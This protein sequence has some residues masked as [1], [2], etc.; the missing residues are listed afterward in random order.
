MY[1]LEARVPEIVC[2]ANLCSDVVDKTRDEIFRTLGKQHLP[3]FVKSNWVNNIT[4][5]LIAG[6]PIL[7]LIL[8]LLFPLGLIEF[9]FDS[10]T[11]EVDI[12]TFCN[13]YKQAHV[14]T[15]L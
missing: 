4:T 11:K 6:T 14:H 2:A 12:N 7:T 13:K 8:Y 5:K 15:M 3:V 9:T 1:S 10:F